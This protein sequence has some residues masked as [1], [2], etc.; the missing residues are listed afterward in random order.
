[1][2]NFAKFAQNNSSRQKRA[3]CKSSQRVSAESKQNQTVQNGSIGIY[4][5]DHIMV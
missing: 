4:L 1:M 5:L 3:A 2:I